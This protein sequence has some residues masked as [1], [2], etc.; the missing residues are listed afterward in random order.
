GEIAL[1]SAARLPVDVNSAVRIEPVPGAFAVVQPGLHGAAASLG[2]VGPLTDS[3]RL[4]RDLLR[5]LTDSLGAVS[6]RIAA[7]AAALERNPAD[8]AAEARLRGSLAAHASILLP[9]MDFLERRGADLE[10]VLAEPDAQYAALGALLRQHVESL[11]AR[12]NGALESF[13]A[14]RAE[15]GPRVQVWAVHYGRGRDAAQVHLAGYDN[16]PA[17]DPRPVD[18][19]SLVPTEAEQQRIETAHQLSREVLA[20][21]AQSRALASRFEEDA[22]GMLTAVREAVRE[23]AALLD[24]LPAP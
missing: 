21:A 20:L 1:R 24:S 17:G 5:Q 3:L 2:S 13:E 23:F 14:A 7:A 19:L 8:A 12:L 15:A 16:L 4:A 10:P 11:D 9:V 6:G 22:R 18:K